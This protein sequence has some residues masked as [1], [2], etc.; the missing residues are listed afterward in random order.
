[1]NQPPFENGHPLNFD[2]NVCV[3]FI[4]A[5]L[6]ALGLVISF[7]GNPTPGRLG[8]RTNYPVS[9]GDC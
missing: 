3:A 6:S 8:A 7:L 1:M 5:W 4:D 2:I 9:M